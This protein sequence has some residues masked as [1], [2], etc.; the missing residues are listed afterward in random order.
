[1]NE[2]CSLHNLN[3]T[4]MCL[5]ISSH[6]SFIKCTKNL[7]ETEPPL[8]IPRVNLHQNKLNTVH[9]TRSKEK[10]LIRTSFNKSNNRFEV[11]LLPIRPTIRSLK[12]IDN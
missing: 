3:L 2:I 7:V 12:N 8:N 1:M 5:I 11:M 4:G 9:M 6:Q 10:P